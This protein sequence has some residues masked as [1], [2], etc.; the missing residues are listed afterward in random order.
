MNHPTVGPACYLCNMDGAGADD[1]EAGAVT[2]KPVDLYRRRVYL[3]PL[4][5][6]LTLDVGTFESVTLD[7]PGK[8]ISVTFNDMVFDN[9]TY[10]NR[11]LRVEKMSTKRPG[12]KFKVDAAFAYI[13]NA[14]VVPEGTATAVVTFS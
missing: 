7:M 14:Y 6:Y 9:C 12:E 4:A 3:E 8:R 2:I 10:T 5:L 13:R 11:R 1:L